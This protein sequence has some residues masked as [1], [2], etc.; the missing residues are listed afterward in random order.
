VPSG[1]LVAWNQVGVAD[2][3]RQIAFSAATH[4][5]KIAAYTAL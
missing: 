1:I 2:T 4:A 3:L 5:R